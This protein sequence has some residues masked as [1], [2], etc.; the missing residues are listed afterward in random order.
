MPTWSPHQSAPST[1]RD[2]FSNGKFHQDS[3]LDRVCL[4]SHLPSTEQANVATADIDALSTLDVCRL[5]NEQDAIVAL[6][7]GQVLPTIAV[8]IDAIADR[9]QIGGRL[10]Y[11]GAGSSGRLGIL[12]AAELP[13]TFNADP[14]QYIALI[15]GGDK[16]LRTAREGVEDSRDAGVA[17]LSA[18]FVTSEDVLIGISASGQTPYTLGAL[19]AAKRLGALTIGLVC[20][21]HSAVVSEG[22]CDF[23]IDPITGP[24]TIAGSTRMKAGTAT[25]MVLN[26][27][28]AG[29]NIKI[30]RTYGNLMVDLKPVTKKLAA[31]A[32]RIIRSIAS[33]FVLPPAYAGIINQDDELDLVVQRCEGSVKLALVVVVS[34]WGIDLCKDALAR[35]NGVLRRVLEDVRYE[36]V[37]RVFTT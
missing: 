5:V 7:V 12:E 14:M 3:L 16:A 31:R 35:R 1:P 24:E 34:G 32:R 23:V 15:A 17:D 6:A 33:Q 25:K 36:T 2:S 27:I 28:S 4:P 37:I 29:L 13:H 30:G 21:S 22:H 11:M 18:L 10:L 26:M 8:V 19:E 9:I 20:V